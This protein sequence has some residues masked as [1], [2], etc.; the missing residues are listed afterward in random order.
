MTSQRCSDSFPTCHIPLHPVTSHD[1]GGR[2]RNAVIQVIVLWFFLCF[3]PEVAGWFHGW[4]WS[5]TG[6]LGNDPIRLF[7]HLPCRPRQREGWLRGTCL[8]D[9]L[10]V[11][12]V[13]LKVH[14]TPSSRQSGCRIPNLAFLERH[15]C[16]SRTNTASKTSWSTAFNGCR[17]TSQFH[18][19]EIEKSSPRQFLVRSCFEVGLFYHLLTV[20]MSHEHFGRLLWRPRTW[21]WMPR[22]FNRS[23]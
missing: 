18:A 14:S 5:L 22:S 2:N 23:V 4:L 9:V 17:I 1:N 6:L 10:I 15:W 11:W 3:S 21:R 20:Q 12:C 13:S 19:S 16:T 7:E 8:W